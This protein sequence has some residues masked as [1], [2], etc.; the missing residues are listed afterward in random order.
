LQINPL[1]EPILFADNTSV[2]ISNG[3]FTH[4]STSANK[5]LAHM[6]E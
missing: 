2:I 6:I 4:F 1:A 3:N 5:E